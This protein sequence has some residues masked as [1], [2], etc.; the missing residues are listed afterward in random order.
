MV[1]CGLAWILCVRCDDYRTVTLRLPPGMWAWGVWTFGI[2]VCACLTATFLLMVEHVARPA[3]PTPLSLRSLL[4]RVLAVLVAVSVIALGMG[5]GYG[6]WQ[7]IGAVVGTFLAL[8]AW[9][10]HR[11]ARATLAVLALLLLG[12]TLASTQSAYQFARRHADEIVAESRNLMDR[13]PEVQEIESDDPRVPQVL[14]RLGARSIV[15]DSTRVAVLVPGL[16]RAE[17]HIYRDPARTLK[18]VWVTHYGKGAGRLQITDRLWM[19][20]DD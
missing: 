17:F 2:G 11:M 7:A 9:R 14:H 8:A 1:V 18:P 12:L 15:V 3:A 20:T 16:W 10:A 19:I 13:L 6:N 4:L 5:V